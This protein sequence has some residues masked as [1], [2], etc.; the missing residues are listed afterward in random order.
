MNTVVQEPIRHGAVSA[1]ASII[2]I[3]DLINCARL[4]NL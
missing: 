4:E 2:N 1:C 3:T